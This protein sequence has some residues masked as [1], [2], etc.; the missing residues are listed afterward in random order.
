MVNHQATKLASDGDK[1]DKHRDVRYR[2]DR[3]VQ[4]Y[5]MFMGRQIRVRAKGS[6][7]SVTRPYEPE[8]IVLH[9]CCTFCVWLQRTAKWEQH[10]EM[11]SAT[12]NSPGENPPGF[13]IKCGVLEGSP[14]RRAGSA[15]S[16]KI[17]K[18]L[19]DKSQQ[20]K[21]RN[22]NYRTPYVKKELQGDLS[23]TSRIINRP[24]EPENTAMER[25]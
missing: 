11:A 15:I 20:A 7:G 6:N 12:E 23:A 25:P 14:K 5:I 3:L 8:A 9:A 19:H 22:W 17:C 10:P 21:S 2:H 24:S 13:N 1:I 16:K 18:S 4:V